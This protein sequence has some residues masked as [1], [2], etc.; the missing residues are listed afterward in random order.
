MTDHHKCARCGCR[1][2]AQEKRAGQFTHKDNI[3]CLEALQRVIKAREEIAKKRDEMIQDLE[4]QL[5]ALQRRYEAD[6][7]LLRDSLPVIE[8]MRRHAERIYADECGPNWGDVWLPQIDALLRR[9]EARLK[10]DEHEQSR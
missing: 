10:G 7:E 8:E 6:T 3:E 1:Y 9:I 5:S 4:A 2:A